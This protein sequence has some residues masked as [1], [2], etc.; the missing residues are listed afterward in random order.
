MIMQLA[1]LRPIYEADPPF[2]TVYLQAQPATA[3]AEQEVRLRWDALRKQLTDAGAHDETLEALDTAVLSEEIAAVQTEGRVLVANRSGLLLEEDFDATRDGG[4]R[5]VFG[6]PPALG[7]YVRQ[8]VRSVRALVVLVDKERATLRREVFTS[9]A[10]LEEAASS[11][12]EGSATETV[13]KPREGGEHHRRMQQR[14]DEAAWLNIRDITAHVGKAA[15]SWKP[16][17][18]VVGGEVQ[19]RKLLL[20]ELPADLSAIAYELETGGGIPNDSADSGGEQALAEELSSLARRITIERAREQTEQF[21]DARANGLAVEGAE[22]IRRA[23]QLGA[24]DT[25]LL[26]YDAEAEDEDQLLQAAAEVDAQVALVGAG[27]AGN[28]A[29]VL[30]YAAPVDQMDVH[31]QAA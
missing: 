4:D 5:S 27:V 11:A 2:A 30:R 29:A 7:D 19:G 23:A 31:P 17:A 28:A 18:V 8:R 21:G 9:S 14:A 15:S 25:L 22:D 24:V 6:E 3:S 16:D 26:R 1:S 10:V 12:V 20:D 13:N